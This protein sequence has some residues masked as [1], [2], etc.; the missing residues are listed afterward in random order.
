MKL[1]AGEHVG[2][3]VGIFDPAIDGKELRVVLH[4]DRHDVSWQYEIVFGDYTAGGDLVC[5]RLDGKCVRVDCRHKLVRVDA[6]LPHEAPLE[7]LNGR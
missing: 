4:T 5:T 1:W 3:H 6:R 2:V 7:G